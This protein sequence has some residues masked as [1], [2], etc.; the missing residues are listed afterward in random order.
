MSKNIKHELEWVDNR[1]P[2]GNIT[3]AGY[4]DDGSRY[5]IL[6]SASPIG[7]PADIR[8]KQARAGEKFVVLKEYPK[9]DYSLHLTAADGVIREYSFEA[10][11]HLCGRDYH[12]HRGHKQI[13]WLEPLGFEGHHE[14]FPH[15]CDKVGLARGDKI[16]YFISRVSLD[17]V[18]V[19][20]YAA[21][22]DY[23]AYRVRPRNKPEILNTQPKKLLSFRKPPIPL[24]WA[25]CVEL[26]EQDNRQRLV[27]AR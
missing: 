18:R 3:C 25:A 20:D 15:R 14:R 27:R 26:C 23:L 21:R 9:L 7:G 16:G 17:A 8:D 11:Q 19:E 12:K 1:D 22:T 10:A 13:E 5:L 6:F 4:G 2:A 24:S